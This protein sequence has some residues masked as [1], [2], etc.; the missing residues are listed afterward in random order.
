MTAVAALSDHD[1][2]APGLVEAI[3]P[4]MDRAFDPRFGE[5]W[6]ADQ[7]RSMLSLPGTFLIVRRDRAAIVGFG[8]LRAIAGE[9][10]LL[11]LAVLPEMRRRGC[12][13]DILEHCITIAQ[14][15]AAETMF[16]E[17]REDNDA[18]NLYRS[19]GF[20]QYNCRPDY[21]RGMDGKRRSALS[22][23]RKIFPPGEMG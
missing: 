3:M 16:L 15:S 13:A 18:I 7:V 9:A 19:A 20:E 22:F 4:V 14:R 21:Y 11:L 23:R 8:L 2:P 12:G 5:A 17:V 6:S 1:A 10:E